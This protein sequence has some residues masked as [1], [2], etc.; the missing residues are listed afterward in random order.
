MPQKQKPKNDSEAQDQKDAELNLSVWQDFKHRKKYKD[1]VRD[2]AQSYVRIGE[3][4]TKV[5]WSWE[6]GEFQG[7][8][9]KL[10]EFGEPLL[11]DGEE[12]DP[13]LVRSTDDVITNSLEESPFVSVVMPMRL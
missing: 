7:F 1:K 12:L 13:I 9:P 11:K 6:H 8:E 10:N 3:V 4:A 5:T 2:W